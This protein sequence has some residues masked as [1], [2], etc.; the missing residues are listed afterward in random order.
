MRLAIQA[1]LLAPLALLLAAVSTGGAVQEGSG[2]DWP[3][4]LGPPQGSWPPPQE[5]VVWREDLAAALD[6]ARESGR[7]LFVTLRCLPCRQ[8]ADFDRAVLEGGPLL[9]PLLARF[10]TVRLTRADDIDLRLLP[11][12]GFQDLDLSWWGWCLSPEGRVY[13]VFGGRDE[14]SD[15]TRI[16]PRA[17]AATLRRVLDHH[18]DPRRKGWNVDGPAP[19]LAGKART[20]RDLE[21]WRSWSRR[22]AAARGADGCLHC[23]EVAEVLR[24]PAIDAGTFD[25]GRDLTPWPFPENVGLSLARDDGL[26]V[27]RVQPGSPAERAGLRA[28]D[29]LAAAGERRLF[30]QADFRGVL[31]RS[32]SGPTHVHVLYRRGT[33]LRSGDLDLAEGWR[34]TDLSWRK[35]IAEGNFG[36]H[37]GFPWAHPASPA[38]RR[39]LAIPVGSMALRPWFGKQRDTPAQLAGL[40][41]GDVI[42]AVN[43]HSPDVSGRAFMVWFR[44]HHDPGSTVTLLARDPRGRE[45]ELRYE[46]R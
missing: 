33:E 25:K 19:E 10:V 5:R 39:R 40:T 29:S 2:P 24:Q 32:P 27:E 44:L 8:C 11:I 16:S 43:G 46:V 9:D 14:V 30:G 12:E 4:I 17:L 1:S 15:S 36:A 35:S 31:H 3:E 23:H 7:P 20:P 26:L 41:A 28:G 45:R 18:S 22:D 37:P 13:A 38:D 6:E 42:V 34:A 21:G